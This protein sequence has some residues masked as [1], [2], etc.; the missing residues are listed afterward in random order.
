MRHVFRMSVTAA[1]L[2]GAAGCGS[3]SAGP[4]PPIDYDTI[5]PIAYSQHVQPLLDA[6]CTTTACHASQTPASGLDLGGYGSVASGSDFGSVVVPFR[7]D[8]SHLYLHVAG[9]MHPRMPL[10][11]DPL[12]A[13]A[14][15]LLERWIRDGAR[16]DDDHPM[17]ADVTHKAFVACQGDNCVAVLDMDPA[18]V[19]RGR[20]IR[21]LDVRAPHSVYVD[22]PSKRLYVSRFETASDN[23]QVYDAQTYELLETTQSGTFPA[24]MKT[25]P[26]GSQLWVTNFDAGAAPDHKVRVF[27][28]SDL[29]AG[30]IALFNLPNTQQPHGLAMTADGARVF[31]TNVL[32]GNLTVFATGI[33][34]GGPDVLQMGVALPGGSASQPQQCVLSADETRLFVSALGTNQVHVLDVTGV[35]AGDWIPHWV[36]VA[37]DAGPW[38]LALSPSGSELWVASWVAESVSVLDV[39][40]PDLPIVTQTLRPAMPRDAMAQALLRPMG[41]AFSPDGNLVYVTSTNDTNQGMG[42]HPPPEGQKY[43]GNV[44]IFDAA[45]RQL[46]TVVEVPNFARFVTFLP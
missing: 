7:P 45:T 11:L 41:I 25:T 27:D 34:A 22:V 24:L 19:T 23:L 32:S 31:V 38:H 10:D 35:D 4:A 3:D 6:N 18:S 26:D 2:A 9:E 16:G 43:P 29:S 14:V 17:Y 46:V 21:L 15:R 40:D 36:S 39:S 13:G 30:P 28:P 8:R 20:L 42:H 37:V 1:L 44:A 33:G 5:D 12:D